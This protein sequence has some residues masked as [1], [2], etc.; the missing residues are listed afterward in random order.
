MGGKGESKEK[1]DMF[2]RLR[3]RLLRRPPGRGRFGKS[4]G[5]SGRE[6]GG[7]RAGRMRALWQGTIIPLSKRSGCLQGGKG[8][9][10][11]GKVARTR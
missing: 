7:G 3:S 11:R 1:G 8:Y 2:S 6:A 5:E 10:G 4:A 9:Y